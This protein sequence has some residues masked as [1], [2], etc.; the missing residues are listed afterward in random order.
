MGRAGH[1]SYPKRPLY[2]WYALGWHR[3][4]RRY[5]PAEDVRA[6]FALEWH[7]LRRKYCAATE[8]PAEFALGWREMCPGDNSAEASRE[9]S[10]LTADEVI[11]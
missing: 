11:E 8:L 3:L 1:S 2:R 9:P 7:H 6:G 10:V 5:C 4:R